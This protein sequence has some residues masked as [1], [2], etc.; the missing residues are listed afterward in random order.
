MIKPKVIKRLIACF[1]SIQILTAVSVLSYI[2][3]EKRELN[4]KYENYLVITPLWAPQGQA[5]DFAAFIEKTAQAVAPWQNVAYL[6]LEQMEAVQRNLNFFGSSTAF[7]TVY[8]LIGIEK[9]D[10]IYLSRSW[11]LENKL[12]M[13]AYADAEK[14]CYGDG[15]GIY[16]SQAVFPAPNTPK[17][18]YGDLKRIYKSLKGKLKALASQNRVLQ[19]KEFDVG[20]FSL[21]SAFG[22]VPPMRTIVLDASVYLKTFE[23]LRQKLNTLVDMNYINELRAKLK[24]APVSILLTSNFSEA[25]GRMSSENEMAA[26]KEFLEAHEIIPNSILLVKP[27]PR[28]SMFKII[29]LQSALGE[30]YSEVILLTADFL[31]YLPFEVLYME[32]FLNPELPRLQNPR[33]FAVSSACLTLEFL[34]QV[35]CNI[36]F[37]SEIVKKFFYEEQVSARIKH[38][39]DLLAAVQEIKNRK[40]KPFI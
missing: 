7:S 38:E 39:T 29:D 15:I 36:G 16:F 17:N 31:F 21:P 1:G 40:V 5:D 37:G 35:G 10:E 12:I 34:F 11:M 32:L 8:N 6:P 28:D 27:H 4:L 18:L 25:S 30:L 22:E 9:A 3:E 13:N 2:E 14:I 19:E 24:N 33:I 20:Y 23:T 26:Y